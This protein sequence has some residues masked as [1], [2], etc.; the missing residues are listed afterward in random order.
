MARF[1]VTG[2]CGFIGSHLV[3]ALVARGERVRILDDLSTGKR[4]N[5]PAA[6]EL[7]IGTITDPALVRKCAEG[8]DGIF[9]L[10]AI[11]SVEL[12][13]SDWLGTHAVNLTGAVNVF[14]GARRPGGL[15]IPIVYA[16]S[17]AVYGDLAAFPLS[18]A[19]PP[20][21][22]TAYGADKLGCELHGRVATLIHSVPTIGL[23][24]FNV[25]GP[26]QDPA[27]PYSG[28]ISVFAERL[29]RRA[30]VTI[31]GDGCQVRDFVA[32]QDV[33]GFFLAAMATPAAAGEVFNVCTGHG[34]AILDLAHV[35][36]NHL[37][38]PPE[39]QFAAER[40][41][42]IR[43]SIG[44]PTRAGRMLNCRAKLPLRAGLALLF[45]AR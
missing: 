37:G 12:S 28:V 34:T 5:V 22:V 29:K 43:A 41:G 18:E 7:V 30:P 16:S 36:A 2:G 33:V 9:H 4:K 17:A 42:D 45:N 3:D 1:L 21:P 38:A 44:D 8:M 32:V 6:A 23:R 35:I 11:A 10:A 40:P 19:N 13:R 39:I 27:S 15:G 31:Y 25:Y 14:D 26:R 20:R 24:L